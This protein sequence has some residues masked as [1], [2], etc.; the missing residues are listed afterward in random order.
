[1]DKES[2]VCAYNGI[3]F[4]HK[5]KNEILLVGATRMDLEGIMLNEMSDRE[6]QILYGFTYICNLKKKIQQTSD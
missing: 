2:L 4:S 1:M 3:V 5:K 6:R